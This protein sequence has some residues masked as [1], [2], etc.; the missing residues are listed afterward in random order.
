MN[1]FSI[2]IDIK[3]KQDGRLII[4][5][6]EKETHK[7]LIDHYLK[8]FTVKTTLTEKIKINNTKKKNNFK[9]QGQGNFIF[10]L[11]Y[12]IISIPFITKLKFSDKQNKIINNDKLL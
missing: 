12:Q 6:K 8:D 2:Q 5:L 7:Y 10:D 4:R 11:L 9:T 3:N 1:D